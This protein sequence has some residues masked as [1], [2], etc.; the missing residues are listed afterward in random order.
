VEFHFHIHFPQPD[1]NWDDYYD[2]FFRYVLAFK[3]HISD[4]DLGGSRNLLYYT[5][6]AQQ[7][8]D[9]RDYDC[10]LHVHDLDNYSRGYD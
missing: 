4:Y 9:Q 7:D 5:K 6:H 10:S 2:G 1:S 3:Y 8:Y